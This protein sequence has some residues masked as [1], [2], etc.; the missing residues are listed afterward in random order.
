[1]TDYFYARAAAR[2]LAHTPSA[3]SNQ[4][5][6]HESRAA[7][8]AAIE[9]EILTLARPGRAIGPRTW[10]AAAAGLV[11]VAGMGVGWRI[12]RRSETLADSPRVSVHVEGQRVNYTLLRGATIATAVDSTEML[13]GDR[14]RTNAVSGTI[15]VL[16]TGTRLAIAGKS[17]VQL[18]ESGANQR[19]WLESGGLRATVAKL[20]PH[21][22]FLLQTSDS[23]IEVHGTVFSVKVRSNS[24]NGGRTQ[25]C[26][27]EG[28]VVWR[29]A[30]RET[31]MVASD[32]HWVGCEEPPAEAGLAPASATTDGPAVEKPPSSKRSGLGVQPKAHTREVP[33]D[34]ARQLLKSNLGEQN[35]LFSAAMTAEREG[36]PAL[37]IARLETL[38]ARYP[39]GSLAESAKTEIAR[40]RRSKTP[41]ATDF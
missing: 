33:T 7:S 32:G 29:Q 4:P 6:D 31:K 8:V 30:G 23:E 20:G 1:M 28:Q 2:L 36:N 18:R 26:L 25:I 38:L 14:V 13:A 35:D 10:L 24:V 3:E 41:S 27:E 17:D 19:F 21:E 5:S 9:R 37:A 11:L 12:A 34:I 40:L 22:R 15:L 16:S 39:D